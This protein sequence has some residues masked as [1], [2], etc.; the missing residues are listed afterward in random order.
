MK[1]NFSFRP[2]CALRSFAGALALTLALAVPVSAADAP[3]LVSAGW[4]NARLQDAGLIVVD[5]RSSIDGGGSRAY[6][7][8][9][10]PGAV[11][12]DYDKAWR[13]TRGNVPFLLPSVPV[14][15]RLIGELGIDETSRVVIVPAGVHV[16]DFGAAARVYWTLK[17]SGVK[18]VSIL[19]GGFAAWQQAKLPVAQGA[20]APS[21]AIF[22]ATMD[23]SL[24][25][26]VS[27]VERVQRD[28]GTTLIDARP[29]SYFSGEEKAA[30]VAAYGHIPGALNLDS[31]DFYDDRSN[32][33]KP[34]DELASIAS[35]LPPGPIVSYCNTGHWAATNW[36]VLHEVLGGH[37]VRL[38][39]GSMIEW[40]A[41]ANRP[42]KSAR[43][44]WDDL[45]KALGLGS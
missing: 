15:E 33:L 11:H 3:P 25:A 9:H 23:D 39:D 17:V 4:L 7:A 14:L 13:V 1:R 42:V 35:K 24:L 18:A 31:T 45:K 44:K 16:T 5:I 36:F 40:A 37:D 32:R 12:S 29:I 2:A 10:V 19:D 34:K 22:T 41:D 28:G 38:Y 26:Q 20:K 43:T 30:R 8:A 6:A 27:D 21:P